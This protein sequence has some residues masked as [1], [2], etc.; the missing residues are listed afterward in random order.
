MREFDEF[1]K[2]AGYGAEAIRNLAVGALAGTAAYGGG[3]HVGASNKEAL[4]AAAAYGLPVTA[5]TFAADGIT[6]ARKRIKKKK[7][8]KAQ[9]ANK[10]AFASLDDMVKEAAGYEEG[11]KTLGRKMDDFDRF[12][13]FQNFNK[14][15]AATA[16]HINSMDGL[17]EKK[18]RECYQL[19]KY[20]P[21]AYSVPLHESMEIGRKQELLQKKLNGRKMLTSNYHERHSGQ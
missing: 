13:L 2:T 18:Q 15:R 14:N 11:L 3:I 19:I 16:A 20:G 21:K 17:R 9:Q 5:A 12:K 10:T 8:E 1:V 7:E 6:A 4:R